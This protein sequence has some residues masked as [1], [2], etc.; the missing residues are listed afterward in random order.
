MLGVNCYAFVITMG[1]LRSEFTQDCTAETVQVECELMVVAV[2]CRNAQDQ[3]S[4]RCKQST[5]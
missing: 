1:A 5:H 3:L 2:R 4:L